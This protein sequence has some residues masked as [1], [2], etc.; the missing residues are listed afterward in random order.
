MNIAIIGIGNLLMTDDGVGVRAVQLLTDRYRFP[1]QVT[2]V[3]GGTLGLEL[4]PQVQDAQ[5]LLIV[6]A[7][8]AG[9][10]PGTVLRYAGDQLQLAAHARLSPHQIGLQDLLALA[11]ALGSAPQETI[12][13]GVQPASVTVGMQLSEPVEAQLEPLT[14]SV[15]EELA[16]WGVHPL[17]G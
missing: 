16:R 7:V 2:I 10:A 3:E 14:S 13:L 5:R 17:T 12:V 6:D 11:A 8:E 15:L 9:A 4:L 1:A